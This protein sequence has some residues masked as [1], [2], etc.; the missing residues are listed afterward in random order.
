MFVCLFVCLSVCP[1]LKFWHCGLAIAI[2]SDSDHDHVFLN[3]NSDFNLEILETNPKVY[4]R[5]YELIRPE[6]I[7]KSDRDFNVNINIFRPRHTRGFKR[8]RLVP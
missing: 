8:L 7:L 2:Y 4:L 5:Y 3:S 1:Q 6:Y